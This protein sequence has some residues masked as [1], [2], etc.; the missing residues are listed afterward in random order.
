VLVSGWL[1]DL[2]VAGACNVLTGSLDARPVARAD[3]KTVLE[4]VPKETASCP[5]KLVIAG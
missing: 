5:W 3:G 1:P 2:T 4:D